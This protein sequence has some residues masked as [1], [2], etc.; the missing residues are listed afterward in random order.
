MRAFKDN[1]L[2]GDLLEQ[3]RRPGTLVC[4]CEAQ[5]FLIEEPCNRPCATGMLRFVARLCWTA[6]QAI[7]KPVQAPR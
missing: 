6:A 5:P 1:L 4:W 7:D 3:V 2:E